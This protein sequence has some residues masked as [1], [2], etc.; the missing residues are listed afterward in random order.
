MNVLDSLN[1]WLLNNPD[2][3]GDKVHDEAIEG[4]DKCHLKTSADNCRTDVSEHLN[5]VKHLGKARQRSKNGEDQR[6]Y[7]DF[8]NPPGSLPG[9]D[10]RGR[11]RSPS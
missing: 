8:L 10:A 5:G 11:L 3:Q 6:T 2:Y 9:G 7:A 4:G 1:S